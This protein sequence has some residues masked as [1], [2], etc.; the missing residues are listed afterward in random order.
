VNIFITGA[1]G[2]IGQYVV[3]EALARGNKVTVLVRSKVPQDWSDLPNL[4]V[5]SGDLLSATNLVDSIENSDIVIHLAAIMSGNKEKQYTNTMQST[6]NLL[7]AMNDAKVPCLIGV[8]SISVLNYADQLPMSIIGE[9]IPVSKLDSAMG[10]YALMKRD[11]EALYEAWGVK[12]GNRL[13]IVRPGLVYDDHNLPDA[14]AGFVRGQKGLAVTHDGRV[15]LVYARS[16]AKALIAI[17][18]NNFEHEIFHLVN[19]DLPTQSEYLQ[20]LKKDQATKTVAAKLI[21]V[22]WKTFAMIS[23]FIRL[24]FRLIG[25]SG[26]VPDSFRENSVAGRLKPLHFSNSHAK[27]RLGWKPCKAIYTDSGKYEE[28]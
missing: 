3:N 7:E 18:Q 15:P 14:H 5:V 25:K 9:N 11:Q 13:A 10:N 2:F 17:A 26:K 23:C 27:E 22:S 24:A 20:A 4:T 19:D 12:A 16:V 21:P 28:V 1:N 6:R 8:S